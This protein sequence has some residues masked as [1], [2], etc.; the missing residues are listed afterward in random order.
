MRWVGI[1]TQKRVIYENM[2]RFFYATLCALTLRKL[3][4]KHNVEYVRLER[5]IK[6]L[7]KVPLLMIHGAKDNYINQP[8]VERFYGLARGGPA[9][10]ELWTVTGAKHNRCREKAGAEYERRVTGFFSKHLTPLAK[11]APKPPVE[12]PQPVVS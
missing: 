10:R 1:F 4:R 2:P 12:Q 11:D 6:Q 3:Q 7:G 5:A 9:A 8:I